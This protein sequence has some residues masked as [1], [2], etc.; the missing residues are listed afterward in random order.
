MRFW[1]T[2]KAG[3][4]HENPLAAPEEPQLAQGRD[5]DRL[6]GAG[7]RR[8]AVRD[9]RAY[10]RRQDHVAGRDLSGAVS[11]HPAHAHHL[12]LAESADDRA[13]RR[14]PGRGGVREP[15]PALPRVLVSAEGP[16]QS[17]GQAAGTAGRA[18]AGRR[19]HHHHLDQG[20]TGRD[21]GPD[22]TGFRPLHPIGAARAGRVRELPA[23]Q[24]QRARRAAGTIDRHGYLQRNLAAGVRADRPDQAR[25]RAVAGPGWRRAAAAGR[26]A[27]G[28][29]GTTARRG[30]RRGA[31]GG[32]P[33]AQPRRAG[34][35]AGAGQGAGAAARR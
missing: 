34:M 22:R 6:H 26:G 4:R 27:R 33:A 10:R 7:V 2:S 1:P 21:R 24:G 11:P 25:G 35:A 17:G 15:W 18:G 3:S 20:K 12:G 31:A 30:R 9:H 28:A 29:A 14:L 32:S 8:R 5:P 16:W 19:Q 23:Q 13:H